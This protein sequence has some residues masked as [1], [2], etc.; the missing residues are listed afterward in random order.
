MTSL[1]R[2]AF[3]VSASRLLNQGLMVLSPI[4]L[5][6]LLSVE[7]FGQYREFLLYVTVLGN[8][9]AFSLPNA[10]LY[11]AGRQPSAA[12]GLARRV[13]LA[14]AATS[15]LTVLGYALVE[16]WLPN[17]PLGPMLLPCMLYVLCFANLDFWEYLWLAQ[18]RA[19]PVLAYT[20]GR[21]LARTGIVCLVAWLTADVLV[22]LWSL[23]ALEAVR[24]LGA[25][26]AWRRLAG[27]SMS[28]AP[29]S[30]WREL[31]EFSLPSGL[32]VFVSTLNRS[33]GGMYVGESLG[34]AALAL[35]VVGGYLAGIVAPLRNSISD[36]LLPSLAAQARQGGTAWVP[37][38]RRSS[39]QVAML[40]FPV[41]VLSWR[42]AEFLISAAFSARYA[43]A[44]PLL[45]WYAGVVALACID[46]A[47]ALRVM[48]RTR[49]MLGVSVVTLAVNLGL[50]AVLVPRF[51]LQ[52]AAAAL[53]A[54]TASGTAYLLWQATRALSL[55]MRQFVP[56][57]GLARVAFAALLAA[58]VLVPWFRA[59]QWGFAGVVTLVLV[60]LVAY[61]VLLR[62]LGL[63][64]AI[65]LQSWIR[66]RIEV[67]LRLRA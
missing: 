19:A 11:F 58:S 31:L 24:L 18:R 66:E 48:G 52:G 32:V 7:A 9:A 35:L 63:S 6:R 16:S 64:E 2:Q 62:L 50:L 20:A 38:W 30:T 10:L 39:V 27:H 29:D 67:L 34:D 46:V 51:G 42:F 55:P 8:L 44:A 59:E 49:S 12:V 61:G 56:I 54:S 17:P 45:Q 28:V 37:A 14:V 41:A 1:A 47:L 5:V 22:M 60:Y 65:E 25:A 40:L 36:V 21:L 57:A 43:T 3:V 4:V 26:I 13:G 15:T 33:I 23:V 53:L